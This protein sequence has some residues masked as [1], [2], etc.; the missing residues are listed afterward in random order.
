M[1]VVVRGVGAWGPGFCSL[2]DFREVLS[3]RADSVA[4][5]V[6]PK[7]ELIPARERR[8]SSSLVKLAVE[9]AQQACSMAAIDPAEAQCVF[10]SGI[11]DAD[12]T[13][14]MCRVLAGPDKLLSPTKFHNSVHN[15]AVGCWSISTGCEQPATFVSG[16]RNSFPMAI[17]EAITQVSAESVP[18]LLVLADIPMPAPMQQMH[19]IDQLFGAAFLLAPPQQRRS[20]TCSN[21]LPRTLSLALMPTESAWPSV[22]IPA[23]QTLYKHSPSARCL[24]LLQALCATQ[25]QQLLLPMGDS[26][27]AQLSLSSMD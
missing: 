12:L 9:V 15:A 8:R 26:L 10:T 18:V 24:S 11:G 19:P 6:A 1:Q 7:P 22:A 14:Y 16:M 17:I 27:A 20:A 25:T 5:V 21:G 3:A 2:S 23:L 13:D 4:E